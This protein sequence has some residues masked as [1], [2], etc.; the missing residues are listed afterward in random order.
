MLYVYKNVQKDLDV[1][2]SADCFEKEKE[3][4]FQ[5]KSYEKAVFGHNA[6]QVCVARIPTQQ[7]TFTYVFQELKKR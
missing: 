4:E 5:G 6:F 2:N 3:L 1:G 7:T